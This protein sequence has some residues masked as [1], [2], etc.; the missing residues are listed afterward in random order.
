MQKAY[1]SKY[2]DLLEDLQA[3]L[4]DLNECEAQ[5][6]IPDWY[7]RFGY[8]YYDFIKFHYARAN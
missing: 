1:D 2:I 4:V 3:S 7:D 8:L 5:Y 6:G